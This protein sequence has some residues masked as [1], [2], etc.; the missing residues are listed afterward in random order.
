M[1]TNNVTCTFNDWLWIQ[2]GAAGD[3]PSPELTLCADY[4]SVSVPPPC[5]RSGM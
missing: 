3:F 5:H 1:N 4:Y 2:A